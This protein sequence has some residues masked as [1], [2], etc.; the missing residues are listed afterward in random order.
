MKKLMVAVICVACT[1]CSWFV[2]AEIKKESSLMKVDSATALAEVGAID[3]SKPT[4]MI[5]VGNGM[6][7]LP[8]AEAVKLKALKSLKRTSAHAEVFDAYMRGE[9]APKK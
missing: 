9:P 3:T 8:T 2:P 7:E 1:G 6:E 5:D 4:T